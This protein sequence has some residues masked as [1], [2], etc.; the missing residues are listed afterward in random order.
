MLEMAILGLLK[1]Q[2][3]H[4]YEL[5]RRLSDS[6]GVVSGV[7]FGSLYPALARL[8]AAGAVKAVRAND[9][10]PSIPMTG[11]L[12]GERAA[13]RSTRKLTRSARGKKV[14]GITDEGEQLFVELLAA[15]GQAGGDDDRNFR[16][17]LAFASHLDH[18]G[19]IGLLEGRRAHLTQR[20]AGSRS[21]V[22]RGRQ[23]LDAYSRTLAEHSAETTM[24]DIDWIDGLLDSERRA[25]DMGTDS[26]QPVGVGS[27]RTGLGRDGTSS[28]TSLESPDQPS[29]ARPRKSTKGSNQ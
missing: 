11:S 17:R 27:P 1:E 2:E 13:Y 14:Y 26:A 10:G 9:S 24:S 23:R 7:S 12:G 29:S 16:L 3:L 25:R 4:G 21:A 6:L 22:E 18:D 28:A 15:E 19:R 20:L 5:K 8:E